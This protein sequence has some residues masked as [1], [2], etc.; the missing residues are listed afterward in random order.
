MEDMLA[1]IVYP[2]GGADAH[3]GQQVRGRNDA[4]FRLGVRPV[5]DERVDG[6]G[7]EP[8]RKPEGGKQGQDQS[9]G[10]VGSRA[11]RRTRSCRSHQR[12]EPYSTLPLER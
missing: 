4:T 8:G 2:G 12:N 11:S 7:E 1:Q 5:L 3:E 6:H 9:E 10:E